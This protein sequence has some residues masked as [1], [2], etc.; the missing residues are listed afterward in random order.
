MRKFSGHDEKV[1]YPLCGGV[2]SINACGKIL[3]NTWTQNTC[4][5]W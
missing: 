2:T 4:K 1:L 5:N 3:Q